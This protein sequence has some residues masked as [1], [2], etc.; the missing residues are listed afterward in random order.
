MRSSGDRPQILV[1]PPVLVGGIL[2]AG[3]LLHYWVYTVTP[4][5]IIPARVSGFVIFVSSGLLANWAQ[6]S[7]T[8]VGT[9][10]LPTR[11]T[12]AIVAD[13]PY[14]YT[15]N[16]LYIAAMGVYIGVTLW[17]DGLIPI[18][19]FPVVFVGLQW[20]IV[21]PEE[22]YLEQKFGDVYREYKARVRRWI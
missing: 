8:R 21:K 20:G 3:V 12:T 22:R 5:A 7:M 19:L 4:F 15:R 10:V 9:N 18:V 1:L 13:G 6:N 16:P 17:V 2:L 11:P 14:R